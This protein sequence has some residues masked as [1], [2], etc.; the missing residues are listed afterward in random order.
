[1]NAIHVIIFMLKAGNHLEL[2]KAY[3]LF[4]VSLSTVLVAETVSIYY[5]GLF[6]KDNKIK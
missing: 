2:I 6:I 1:M 4:Y 3:Q 5:G